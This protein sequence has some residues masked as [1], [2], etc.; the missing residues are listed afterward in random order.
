[1][2]ADL[3]NKIGGRIPVI[4][5]INRAPDSISA[6]NT[7]FDKILGYL[8][9][10][11]RFSS[12]YLWSQDKIVVEGDINVIWGLLDDIWYWKHNKTSPYDPAASVLPTTQK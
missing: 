12:R 10:F 7:N 6:I 1:L 3:I 9:D 5:G 11:P 8:R 4:K 2:F